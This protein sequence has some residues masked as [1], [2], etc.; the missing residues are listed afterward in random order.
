MI[1]GECFWHLL[2]WDS[3]AFAVTASG[4]I[5]MGSGDR[6]TTRSPAFLQRS[7]TLSNWGLSCVHPSTQ[8][9]FAGLFL[10]RSNIF[11]DSQASIPPRPHLLEVEDDM[12]KNMGAS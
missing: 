7:L 10:T 5:K 9:L 3:G 1:I 6:H 12:S 11:R 4:L 2:P 8:I